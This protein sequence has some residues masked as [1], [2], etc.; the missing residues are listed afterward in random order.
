MAE[1]PDLDLD[2]LEDEDHYF[3]AAIEP[4]EEPEFVEP[5]SP[6]EL[7]PPPTVGVVA[8]FDRDENG[9]VKIKFKLRGASIRIKYNIEESED[10]AEE[11]VSILPEALMA[12]WANLDEQEEKK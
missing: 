6:E 2:K 7:T 4:D 1:Q 5:V 3:S 10:A 8:N 11:L 9:D 12:L